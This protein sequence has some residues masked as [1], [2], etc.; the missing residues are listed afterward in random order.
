[1]PMAVSPK[2][3]RISPMNAGVTSGGR[4]KIPPLSPHKKLDRVVDSDVTITANSRN[5]VSK[6][7]RLHEHLDNEHV[8]YIIKYMY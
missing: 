2:P 3:S 7:C 8:N 6:L 5:Y 1:M 4:H